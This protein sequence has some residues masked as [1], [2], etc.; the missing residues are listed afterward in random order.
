MSV[1]QQLAARLCVAPT[2][3]AWAAVHAELAEY[4]QRVLVS[5]QSRTATLRNGLE[6]NE[7]MLHA[8]LEG[9]G[10]QLAVDRLLEIFERLELPVRLSAHEGEIRVDLGPAGLL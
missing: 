2:S 10:E 5:L 6:L 9:R 7:P 4:A 3:P 8:L 1:S